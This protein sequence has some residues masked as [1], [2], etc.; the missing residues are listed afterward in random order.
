[1][2]LTNEDI[3]RKLALNGYSRN[4]VHRWFRLRFHRD[5]DHSAE[6][7]YFNEW[8]ERFTSFDYIRNALDH[9]SRYALSQLKTNP[10]MKVPS[11]KG[12][13]GQ[14]IRIVKVER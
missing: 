7:S 3:D 4:F 14:C 5:P 9:E 1:M 2:K 6:R 12:I 8:L 13:G 10:K 11:Y